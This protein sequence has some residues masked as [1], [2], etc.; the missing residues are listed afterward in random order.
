MS[1]VTKRLAR[2]ERQVNQLS[3]GIIIGDKLMTIPEVANY[4][5]VSRGTVERYISMG[6]LPMK[7]IGGVWR[8]RRS[9]LEA[10]FDNTNTYTNE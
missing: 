3:K 1:D 7:R 10:W 5:R 2:L 4:L 9:E 8:I 6:I